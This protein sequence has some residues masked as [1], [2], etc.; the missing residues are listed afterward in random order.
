MSAIANRDIPLPIVRLNRWLLVVGILAG[1][2]LQQPLFTTL[3]FAIL[4]PATVIGQR[5]SLVFFVGK[6]LF[7]RQIPTAEREDRRMQRFNNTIATILLGGAQLAFLAGATIVGWIL[8]LMV[9][10]AASIALAGFCIGC[11]LYYQLKLQRYR[12][13]GT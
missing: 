5:A 7:A 1:L 2:A 10:A 12:L 11:F 13:F 9:A 6:R 4:L 8:A 3:L